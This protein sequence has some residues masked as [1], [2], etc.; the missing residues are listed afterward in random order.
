[1]L[2]QKE[3]IDVIVT[4]TGCTKKEAK[5]I[6]DCMFEYIKEQI[7]EDSPIKL[8]GLGV[9]KLRKTAAKEQINLVTGQAEIVPEHYAVTFK[10]YF[11]IDPKPEAIEVEDEEV[12]EVVEEVIPAV[13]EEVVEEVIS[14]EE[15]VVE[16]EVVEEVVPVEEEVVEEVVPVEEEV[17]EEVNDNFVWVYENEK[18]TTKQ[19][20]EL[21][22]K[23]TSLSKEEVNSALDVV[24]SNMEKINKTTCD[25]KETNET[26]DFIIEK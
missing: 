3:W 6:Y 10:P 23:S 22:C 4:K 5:L 1:M 20:L 16:E 26:F 9:F 21:I 14:V 24:K 11:E 18:L 17:I 13:E 15:E 8:Q 2:K 19:V 12:I 25:V 7:S